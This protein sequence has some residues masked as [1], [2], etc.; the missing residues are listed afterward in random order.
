MT[1]CTP[2]IFSGTAIDNHTSILTRCLAILSKAFNDIPKN[3]KKRRWRE[4]RAERR[5]KEASILHLTVSRGSRVLIDDGA[6]SQSMTDATGR[7]LIVHKPL[8]PSRHS[9]LAPAT[10]SVSVPTSMTVRTSVSPSDFSS[11]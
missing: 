3:A 10:Y 6:S 11:G 1:P 8:N 2:R 9:R 5:K 4:S 7:S